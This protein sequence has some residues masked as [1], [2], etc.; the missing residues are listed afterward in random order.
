[1]R[2][3]AEEAVGLIES[4]LEL[5]LEHPMFV[6][7]VVDIVGAPARPCKVWSSPKAVM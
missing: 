5:E 2:V 7:G 3:N 4:E 1:M 6:T